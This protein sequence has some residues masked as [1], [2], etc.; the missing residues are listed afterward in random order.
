MTIAATI[1]TLAFDPLLEGF[2][3]ERLRDFLVD[4]K[5]LSVDSFS[6]VQGGIPYWSLCITYRRLRGPEAPLDADPGKHLELQCLRA[7]W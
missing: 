6:F 1:L 7:S 4:R 3:N 2:P 5:I